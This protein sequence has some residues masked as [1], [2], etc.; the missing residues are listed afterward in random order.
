[1]ADRVVDSRILKFEIPGVINIDEFEREYMKMWGVEGRKSNPWRVPVRVSCRNCGE[2]K[3]KMKCP[4]C[5]GIGVVGGEGVCESWCSWCDQT[6]KITGRRWRDRLLWRFYY[7]LLDREHIQF[8]D[9]IVVSRETLRSLEKDRARLEW[10][11]EQT[12][13]G[14]I[15]EE[16]IEA[17]QRVDEPKI[18]FRKAID[19]SGS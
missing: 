9:P 5:K 2:A 14:N 6:G 10:L 17:V 13:D 3:P 4:E 16:L 12:I 19:R 8:E 1:M 11:V 15:K 7:W 18:S